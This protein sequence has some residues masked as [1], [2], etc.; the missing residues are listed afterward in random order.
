VVLATYGDDP[1][2]GDFVGAGDATWTIGAR[3]WV[4]RKL[5]AARLRA[6]EL[7]RQRAV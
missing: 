3:A 7:I 1:D 2:G 5:G 4:E 6:R